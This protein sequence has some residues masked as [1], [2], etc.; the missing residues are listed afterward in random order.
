MLQEFEELYF[1]FPALKTV[2]Y[3]EC[4]FRVMEAIAHRLAEER[5]RSF[6]GLVILV[7][8]RVLSGTDLPQ[9]ARILLIE[10]FAVAK[11]SQHLKEWFEPS[12]AYL[13]KGASMYDVRKIC[14]V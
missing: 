6:A 10:A 12:Q 13:C 2:L 5:P 9:A 14:G 7:R 1:T 11:A 3:A 4:T 8:D